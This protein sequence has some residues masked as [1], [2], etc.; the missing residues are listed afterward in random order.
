MSS[1]LMRM[2]SRS[3]LASLGIGAALLATAAASAQTIPTGNNP[4]QARQ[5]EQRAMPPAPDMPTGDE[6]WPKI[7]FDILGSVDY[8]NMGSKT[9]PGRKTGFVV[10]ADATLLLE[11]NDAL[12][13]D[14]L[15]QFKPRQP[16]DASN[17]NKDLFINRGLTAA[18]AAR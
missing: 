9:G 8:A 12:S 3:L 5:I 4:A 1:Q 16:L 13:L 15:F 14:G 10:W 6:G 18:K 11:F 17:P 7:S 2:N